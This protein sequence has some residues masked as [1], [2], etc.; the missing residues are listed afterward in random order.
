M[1]KINQLGMETKQEPAENQISDKGLESSQHDKVNNVWEKQNWKRNYG[2]R[3]S[4]SI[5]AFSKF[6]SHDFPTRGN[7]P[8]TS[9]FT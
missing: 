8:L 7:N 6:L 2:Q 5:G 1:T 9:S 3:E 4:Y